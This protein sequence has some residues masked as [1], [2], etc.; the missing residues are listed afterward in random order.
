VGG[1]VLGDEVVIE[2]GLEPGEALAAAGSFKLHE[3]V[4]VVVADDVT[5]AEADADAEAATAARDAAVAGAAGDV[6]ADAHEAGAGMA[7]DSSAGGPD[8]VVPRNE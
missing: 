1:P 5:L 2:S 3:G 6:P 8:A 4:L 7:P